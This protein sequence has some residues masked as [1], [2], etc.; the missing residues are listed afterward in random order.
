MSSRGRPTVIYGAIRDPLD[1]RSLLMSVGVHVVALVAVLWV[2]P[3]LQPEPIVYQAI[4]IRVVSAPPVAAPPPEEEV[5]PAAEEELVVETLDEPVEEVEVPMPVEEEPP[6]EPEETPPP[7]PQETLPPEPEETP[8]P[9]REDPVPAESE[10][11]EEEDGGEDINVRLQGVQREHPAYWANII[12]Q[13]GRCFR[14][15]DTGNLEAV[16]EFM[17]QHDGSVAEIDMAESSGSFV[18][19]MAVQ[20]AV[21]CAGAPGRIGPLPEGYDWDVLP[22]QFRFSPG[23][24]R[25]SGGQAEAAC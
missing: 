12:R 13:I 5:P 9:E 18:F 7:E 23:S 15:R 14:P 1:T 11:S 8:P 25:D 4:A 2:M 3:A 10:E 17:I 19:D 21:E 16:V 6:P 22:V 20:G 24:S